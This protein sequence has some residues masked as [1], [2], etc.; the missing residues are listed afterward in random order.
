V[1]LHGVEAQ[2]NR[3]LLA[4]SHD[5]NHLT[6]HGGRATDVERLFDPHL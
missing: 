3:G 2:K 6:R 5:E 1:L 4:E